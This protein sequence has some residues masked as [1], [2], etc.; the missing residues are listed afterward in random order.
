MQ[1][2]FQ[3]RL[4]KRLAFDQQGGPVFSRLDSPIIGCGYNYFSYQRNVSAQ[5]TPSSPAVDLMPCPAGQFTYP[6]Y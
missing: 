5:Q 3:A 6:L 4:R 2:I 1:L